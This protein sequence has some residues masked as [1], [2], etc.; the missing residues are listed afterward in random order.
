MSLST[1]ILFTLRPS[2]GWSWL[3]L[4][5]VPR[6]FLLCHL[7][8]CAP[9]GGDHL[10][11]LHT[12]G[13]MAIT[14]PCS[15]LPCGKVGNLKQI[16]VTHTSPPIAALLGWTRD[17]GREHQLQKPE[18][19]QTSG[20]NGGEWT[21]AGPCGNGGCTRRP[22]WTSR[23]DGLV[24]GRGGCGRLRWCHSPNQTCGDWK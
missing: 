2:S 18:A 11:L 8:N 22:P 13:G 1:G 23:P 14:V 3:N 9:F 21:A 4:Q 20:K 5:W 19:G 17:G 24:G 12:A 6:A 10:L 16:L 15:L 7:P